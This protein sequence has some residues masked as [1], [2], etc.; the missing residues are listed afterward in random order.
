MIFVSSVF[1]QDTLRIW[2]PDTTFEYLIKWCIDDDAVRAYFKSDTSQVAVEYYTRDSLKNGNFKA[3]FP[4]GQL[5][6]WCVYTLGKRYGERTLYDMDGNILVKGNY[7]EGFKDGSWAFKYC[8]CYGKFNKDMLH[9]KWMC[10]EKPNRNYWR[11]AK[12][13]IK[14]GEGFPPIDKD[15]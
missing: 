15:L 10:G 9:G 14:K 11:F 4:N 12:G 6:D 5:A 3:Y 8:N 2:Q 7:K 1:A 13:E